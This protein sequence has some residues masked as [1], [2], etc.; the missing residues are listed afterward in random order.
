MSHQTIRMTWKNNT[1]ECYIKSD[2]PLLIDDI[3]VDLLWCRH[4]WLA[5]FLKRQSYCE[6]S[7]R[8]DG[9]AKRLLHCP[10]D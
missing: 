7:G 6:T 9:A 8:P 2:A 3:I 10:C 5:V 1:L 4:V